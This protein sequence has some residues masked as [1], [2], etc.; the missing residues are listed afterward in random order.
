MKKI[1]NITANLSVISR[2]TAKTLKV[3]LESKGFE[4]TDKLTSKV[5]LIVCIGGDG[6]FLRTVHEYNFTSIPIIGINTGHLGF[7]GKYIHVK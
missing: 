3:K 2:E 1:I 4:V 6:S 5:D 7:F